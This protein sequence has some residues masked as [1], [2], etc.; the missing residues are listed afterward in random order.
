MK[1]NFENALV[2]KEEVIANQTKIIEEYDE[3]LAAL[4]SNHENAF[5]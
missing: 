5:K 2:V 1:A 4:V 3:R